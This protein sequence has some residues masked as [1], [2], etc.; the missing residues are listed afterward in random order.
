V[1]VDSFHPGEVSQPLCA[2]TSNVLL[3]ASMLGKICRM[4]KEKWS[5]QETKALPLMTLKDE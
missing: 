2:T 3:I 4:C 1:L 5:E